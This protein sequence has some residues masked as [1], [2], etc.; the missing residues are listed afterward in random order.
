MVRTITVALAAAA[1]PVGSASAA[2]ATAQTSAASV[3]GR[4]H[5]VFSAG[6]IR[7]DTLV[8]HANRTW[9]VFLPG[10]GAISGTWSVNHATYTFTETC[11]SAKGRLTAI[12][13]NS[14]SEPGPFKGCFG[15]D[16]TWYAVRI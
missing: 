7:N 13:I 8:V 4:Y 1:L 2:S 12:G 3:V 10:G 11:F 15:I 14:K 6:N 9:T 16:G 5:Q